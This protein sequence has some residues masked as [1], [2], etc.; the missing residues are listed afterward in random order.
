[1]QLAALLYPGEF[2][3]QLPRTHLVYPHMQT[4]V[5]EFTLI[6]THKVSLDLAPEQLCGKPNIELHCL[7]TYLDHP[8]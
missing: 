1:M 3:Y 4:I 6:G 2:P 7:C 5:I 8:A